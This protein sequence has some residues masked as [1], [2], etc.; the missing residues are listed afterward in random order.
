MQSFHV[1]EKETNDATTIE[2]KKE[3]NK[4]ICEDLAHHVVHATHL[5]SECTQYSEAVQV[6]KSHEKDMTDATQILS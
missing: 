6:A 2:P 3:Y 4:E 1:D 5:P